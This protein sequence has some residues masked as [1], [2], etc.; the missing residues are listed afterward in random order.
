MRYVELFEGGGG[1]RLSMTR[2]LMF[3]AFWPA[4]YVV[5]REP[6]HETLGWYLGAFVLGYV[7][8]KGADVF[9]GREKLEATGDSDTVS[10]TAV[11][12]HVV[13]KRSV[14]STKPKRRAF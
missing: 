3:L 11:T 4:T 8:G 7:G 14:K 1:N 13:E 6:N 10:D 5:V 12:S 2:L 9:M